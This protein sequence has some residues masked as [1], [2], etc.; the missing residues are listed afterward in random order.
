MCVQWWHCSISVWN[1]VPS[2]GEVNTISDTTESRPHAATSPTHQCGGLHA[3]HG[4]FSQPAN[5]KANR[6]PNA[7]STKKSVTVIRKVRETTMSRCKELHSILK[8]AVTQITDFLGH[9]GCSESDFVSL[10]CRNHISVIHWKCIPMFVT[11]L[12]ESRTSE[13][14]CTTLCTYKVMPYAFIW[15]RSSPNHKKVS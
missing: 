5:W 4:V 14:Y 3:T 2:T 7:L 12:S 9:D 15:H 6:T 1:R 13:L 11:V 8:G 10:R